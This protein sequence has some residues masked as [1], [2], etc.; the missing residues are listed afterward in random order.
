MDTTER[1]TVTATNAITGE[2]IRLN[3]GEPLTNERGNQIRTPQEYG[4]SITAI[5]RGR[6]WLIVEYYSIWERGNSGA[7]IGTYYSALDTTDRRAWG[8]ILGL[9]DRLDIEPPAAIPT[10]E[11]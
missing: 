9:C 3:I 6:R 1:R 10:E 4:V 7:C 5:Y 2:K 11:A 8:E